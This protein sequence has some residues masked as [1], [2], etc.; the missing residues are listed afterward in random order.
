MAE[1]E[2]FDVISS[3]V[4]DGKEGTIILHNIEG[5]TLEKAEK[6]LAWVKER[7]KDIGNVRIREHVELD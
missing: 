2:L 6:R 7:K 5:M 1:E 4:R 3:K